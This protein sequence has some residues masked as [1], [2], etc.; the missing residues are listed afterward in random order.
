MPRP[1]ARTP[2]RGNLSHYEDSGMKFCIASGKGGAGKTTVT[3]SLAHVW[4]GPVLAADMDAEAPNLHLFLHPQLRHE[5]PVNM[6]VPRLVPERCTQCGACRDICR[7]NA[8]ARFVGKVSFFTDMCHGCG[9]CFAVCPSGALEEGGRE[10]GSLL[11]GDF[12]GGR[13]LMGKSRIG[14]AM[15]PPLLRRLLAAVD[16]M[17]AGNMLTDGLLPAEAAD[18]LMD[19][20]PGVSCPA[21]TAARGADT[22]LLVAEP[23]PF[24]LHDFRLACEA[25][26][27]LHLPTA[28]VLN[29]AEQDADCDA[30]VAAVCAQRGLPL[31]GAL[32]F[33]ADAARA[34]AAGKLVAE[35]SPRWRARFEELALRLRHFAESCAEQRATAQQ[36]AAAQENGHV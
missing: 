1:A 18:A 35:T 3:A 12:A 24:G 7:Y 14:E 6:I 10:L 21:M 8:I 30:A 15:T 34:Y 16:T 23:T 9:G 32:P 31:L 26:A 11:A 17:L 4:P 13:F 22:L 29:R 33:D 2:E 19:A 36:P 25:F 20:P 5:E 27:R 28:V